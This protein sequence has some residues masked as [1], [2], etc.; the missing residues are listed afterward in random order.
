MKIERSK[1]PGLFFSSKEKGRI[2]RAVQNAEKNTSG[3]IRVHLERKAKED[4]LAHACREFDRLGMN[5]T[6]ERNGV[7]IFMG[8]H[9]KRFAI[10]ADQGINDKVP[11]NFWKDIV[12]AME[13]AFA[14]DRFADGI[15]G[16]I[17]T[18]GE[19]LRAYFPYQRED[20]NE[21]PDEISY[22]F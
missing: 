22:S 14:E 7:L 1:N 8:V 5:K 18:I 15:E 9:S 4:I 21:L 11:A 17:L 16:A 3:E 20:I 6:A 2:V 13:R 19:K 12:Q 10:W